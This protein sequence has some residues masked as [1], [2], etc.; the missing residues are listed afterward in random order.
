MGTSNKRN[1]QGENRMEDYGQIKVNQYR[2]CIIVPFSYDDSFFGQMLREKE[3]DYKEENKKKKEEKD[4]SKFCFKEFFQKKQI[5]NSEPFSEKAK[6]WFVEKDRSG[7][8]E[9]LILQCYELKDREKI[10]LNPTVKG[11]YVLSKEQYEFKIRKIK[12]WFFR[13]GQGFLTLELQSENVETIEDILAFNGLRWVNKDRKFFWKKK[14]AKDRE[15]VIST[16]IKELLEKCLDSLKAVGVKDWGIMEDKAYFLSV[17]ISDGDYE[18]ENENEV[19]SRLCLKYSVGKPVADAQK[20][21]MEF[22]STYPYIHCGICANT[23]AVLGD[24]FKE[25]SKQKEQSNREFMTVTYPENIF[26]HYLIT[27]LYYLSRYDKYKQLKEEWESDKKTTVREMR[28]KIQIGTEI[29]KIAGSRHEQMDKIF[30]DILC[31]QVWE[32]PNKLIKFKKEVRYDVFISYRHDGGQYL[33]LLLYE[34]LMQK[35]VNVFWDKACLRAGHFDEQ[36][37]QKIEQSRNLIVVLS[38]QCIERLTEEGDWIC[39][40]LHQAFRNEQCPVPVL[41]VAME[42]VRFPDKK[43][44]ENLLQSENV[45]KL[46]KESREILED[47]L[48]ELTKCQGIQTDVALFD[49]VIDRIVAALHLKNNENEA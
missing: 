47:T 1:Y 23:V 21:A 11:I 16:N 19:L 44:V 18:I 5:K 13:N 4:Y 46:S 27:Y 32:F 34:H 7:S 8:T 9:Q 37:Y 30:Y 14:V 45:R 29:S 12:A 3:A 43:M 20:N 40:E 17:L 42:N 31:N 39:K 41:M 35:G 38:P 48:N 22:Y 33:A 28:N 2:T 10:N 24:C 26:S 15:E 6:G 36:L 25:K 49:G